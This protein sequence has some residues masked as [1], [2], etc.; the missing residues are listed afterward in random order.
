MFL[1]EEVTGCSYAD[2]KETTEGKVG[3]AGSCN[4]KASVSSLENED[5][6]STYLLG[7]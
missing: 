7:D 4:Q 5:P 6:D 3:D 2:G 1:V